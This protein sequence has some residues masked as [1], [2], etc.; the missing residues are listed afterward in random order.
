MNQSQTP[1]QILGEEGIRRLA[2]AF[3]DVMDSL[4][5]AASIR[6]M[7]ARDRKKPKMTFCRMERR[8]L[9]MNCAI[10]PLRWFLMNDLFS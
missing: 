1:Y 4:H 5:E 3:Y 10:A 2:N 9:R 7:H 6:A 8:P